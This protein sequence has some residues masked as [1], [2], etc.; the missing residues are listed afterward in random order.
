MSSS[1]S[2]SIFSLAT[3]RVVVPVGAPLAVFMAPYPGQVGWQVK[4]YTGGTLEILQ[5]TTG[6]SFISNSYS[7]PYFSAGSTQT[8]QQL[9]NLSGTGYLIG[10]SEAL[11][12]TGPASFY[13]S[14]T[15]A[16]SIAMVIRALSAGV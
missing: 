15:G 3:S 6:A 4:Y 2:D 7:A 16:T 5:S 10:T 11:S 1:S 13:L 9:A 12:L 8:P 14:S